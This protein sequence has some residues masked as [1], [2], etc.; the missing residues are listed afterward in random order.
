MS[1][2]KKVGVIGIGFVGGTLRQWFESRGNAPLLYDKYKGLGSPEEV[3]RADIIFVA[4]PT[5]F[6]EK[7]KGYDKSAI[8]EAVGLI[9]D[10]KIVVIKSTVLPGTSEELQ[11]E[12]PGKTILFSPEFLREKTA[13]EDFQSPHT[14]IVSYARD[15]E[16]SRRAAEEVL[17]LLPVAPFSKVMRSREAE[18]IKCFRNIFLATRVVFANQLYDLCEALGINY[19]EVKDGAAVDPRVGGSYF[20]IWHEGYRGYGRSCLPK[21]T[22]ALIALAENLGVDFRLLKDV[23][24]INKKLRGEGPGGAN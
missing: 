15:D 23:D 3:N 17:A 18:M 6:D 7:S 20:E 2:T 19:D 13:W 16:A 8:R 1:E 14:Q 12:H 9:Q 21:D 10:G 5:P 4:V 24:I 22:Q 11:G